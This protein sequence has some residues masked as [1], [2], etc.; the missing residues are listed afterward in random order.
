LGFTVPFNVAL[1]LVT[2]VAA[3][4][5]TLGAWPEGGVVKERMLPLLVPKLFDAWI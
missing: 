2:E 4:V 1:L 5:V 3:A